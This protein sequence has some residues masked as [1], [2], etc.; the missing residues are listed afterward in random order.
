MLAIGYHG[1]FLA[2]VSVRVGGVCFGSIW[3]DLSKR[4]AARLSCEMGSQIAQLQLARDQVNYR[5]TFKLE[6]ASI[7]SA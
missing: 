1:S 5:A 3:L 7:W 4:S 6:K 2:G